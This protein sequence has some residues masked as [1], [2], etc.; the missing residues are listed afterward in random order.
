MI[1]LMGVDMEEAVEVY[2]E[3]IGRRYGDGGEGGEA[4]LDQHDPM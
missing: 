4:H 1:E 2:G 3:V